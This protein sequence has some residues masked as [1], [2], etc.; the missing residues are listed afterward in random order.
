MILVLVAIVAVFF[1]GSVC[2]IFALIVL[3]IH[4]E[5]RR[6]R[7]THA[8]STVGTVSRRLLTTRTGE[9]TPEKVGR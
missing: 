7:T 9:K 8:P 6:A 5:E 2:G 1:A 3:G 4:A